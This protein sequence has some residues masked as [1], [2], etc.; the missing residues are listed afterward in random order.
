MNNFLFC[1]YKCEEIFTDE[2][3]ADFHVNLWGNLK[4]QE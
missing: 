2:Q 4:M 3:T 1:V